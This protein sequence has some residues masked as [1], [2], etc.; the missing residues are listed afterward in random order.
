MIENIANL[1][2]G[3]RHKLING[4]FI[5]YSENWQMNHAISTAQRKGRKT[6]H[7]RLCVFLLYCKCLY[8]IL[9][10][11]PITAYK[12]KV[13]L[14]RDIADLYSLSPEMAKKLHS[15]N[16]FFTS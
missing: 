15:E 8:R 2:A 12:L 5:T 9:F 7:A 1:I 14:N 6:T 13:K 10:N 11:S 4:G 16:T 3:N